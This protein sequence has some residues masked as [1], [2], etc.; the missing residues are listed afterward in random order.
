MHTGIIRPENKDAGHSDIFAGGCYG[1][2]KIR[3]WEDFFENFP[4][5]FISF[6]KIFNLFAAVNFG[7]R[8]RIKSRNSTLLSA[9][10]PRLFAMP[11]ESVLIRVCS[12]RLSLF[13]FY[14]KPKSN[15]HARLESS[16]PGQDKVHCLAHAS[17]AD[18]DS[19]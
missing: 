14:H 8:M 3:A 16:L 2:I 12:E 13:L 15:L 9:F 1:N 18:A 4:G 10:K 5:S 17:S 11:A 6:Y 7:S 19:Q